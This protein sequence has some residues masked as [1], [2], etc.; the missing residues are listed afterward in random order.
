[1]DG[2]KCGSKRRS[3]RLITMTF[4][5]VFLTSVSAFDKI[6]EKAKIGSKDAH[7]FE[8]IV[9]NKIRFPHTK[10]DLQSAITGMDTLD[11]C[12]KQLEK[13]KKQLESIDTKHENAWEKFNIEKWI[14]IGSMVVMALMIVS[15]KIRTY[16]ASKRLRSTM[17]N[18]IAELRSNLRLTQFEFRQVIM[19][20]Q[21]FDIE[22]NETTGNLVQSRNVSLNADKVE[23]ADDLV[24]STVTE[25]NEVKG[26][27]TENN[28]S[29][30]GSVIIVDNEVKRATVTENE[31]NG[32]FIE[33]NESAE[34]SVIIVD[35]NEVRRSF[36][37]S[38]LHRSQFL[39][40]N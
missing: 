5:A 18:E 3:I 10:I 16:Y 39:N 15:I 20:L 32:T 2:S 7:D 19:D 11:K 13:I 40:L 6:L 23:P 34:G 28:V 12:V 33:N 37:S 22:N 38:P 14:L 8:T 24:V 35:F 30:E 31:V 25:N 21:S 1:M 36:F 26:S 27:S 9:E 4:L 29:A 17:N